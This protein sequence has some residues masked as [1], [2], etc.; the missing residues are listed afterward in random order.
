MDLLLIKESQNPDKHY[1]HFWISFKNSVRDVLPNELKTKIDTTS[2][3]LN[4]LQKVKKYDDII[5][6]I[7]SFLMLHANEI[8]VYTFLNGD[9]LHLMRTNIRR[10]EKI[11][12]K[13]KLNS[14]EFHIAISVIN[15]NSRSQNNEKIYKVINEYFSACLKTNKYKSDLCTPDEHYNLG[16]SLC[17]LVNAAIKE[18]AISLLENLQKHVDLKMYIK[19]DKNMQN[20][21]KISATKMIKFDLLEPK[22]PEYIYSLLEKTE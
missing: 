1:E 3:Y 7:N 6:E 22:T 5:K 11:D 12:P 17:N 13:F 18:K 15:Y 19:A 16:A 14:I 20:Y 21:N 2:A 4:D 10:W 8:I 9:R